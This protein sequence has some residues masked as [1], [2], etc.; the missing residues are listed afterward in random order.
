VYHFVVRTEAQLPVLVLEGAPQA[1]DY[2]V[3]ALTLAAPFEADRRSHGELPPDEDLEPY[4]AIFLVEVPRM[5]PQVVQA[6]RDYV[7]GG[8][9]LVAFP[10]ANTEIN[11]WNSADLLPATLQS[12]VQAQEDERPRPARGETAGERL[13]EGLSVVLIRRLYELDPAADARVLANTTAGRPFLVRGRI[14]QG[15]VYLFAVSARDEYSNLPKRFPFIVLLR[16]MLTA[17]LAQVG[18]PLSYPALQPLHLQLPG[19][20]TELI[21][22]DGTRHKL[23]PAEDLRK[24][25]SF[26]HT[27]RA[28]IYR[29]ESDTALGDVTADN[30]APADGTDAAPG[31]EPAGM[32][33][34]AVNVPAEEHSLERL[35]DDALDRIEDTIG[36]QI[37]VSTQ[38]ETGTARGR[39][40]STR[41]A[42]PLAVLA[43]LM[44]A[45][46]SAMAWFMDRPA[47]TSEPEPEQ[48]PAS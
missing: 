46:A 41:V 15:S 45:A 2:L 4:A 26:P 30:G 31:Q 42:F 7:E 48:E 35:D 21:A 22:P 43:M 13:G 14:G 44:V 12:V 37:I 34:A 32:A 3:P 47:G 1:A 36:Q 18:Q 24:P 5:D 8:G 17:H 33:V 29:V 23:P 28:G 19:G 25:R 16:R 6:L 27:A 11:P 38:N 40:D 10:G 20:I 9:L 39:A